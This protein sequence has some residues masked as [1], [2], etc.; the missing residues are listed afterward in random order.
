MIIK[1]FKWIHS[2]KIDLLRMY[3]IQG[4]VLSA[5]DTAVKKRDNIH[6]N[7]STLNLLARAPNVQQV[8]I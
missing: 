8:Q 4:I 7:I 5:G 2:L 1:H 6:I 3:S